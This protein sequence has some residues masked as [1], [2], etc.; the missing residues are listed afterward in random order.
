MAAVGTLTIEMAANVARLQRDM[1]RAY[2]TVDGAMG[3]INRSVQAATRIFGGFAAALSVQKIIQQADA[4]SLLNS[5]LK[6][7]TSSQ[8]ELTKVQNALFAISSKTY[9]STEATV[10]LYAA[11]ARSTKNLNVTQQELLT[12]VETFN[13]SI[14]ISGGSVQSAQ[15]AITQ[16]NQAMA[17]GVLRGE[18]FN[19]ISEQA[20]MIMELLSES[21]GV[22]RG[23]LR[24]MAKEG[25][26]TAELVLPALIDG[27]KG[28]DEQFERMPKTVGQATN[29]LAQSFALL[30]AD[31]DKSTGASA[32]L[33]EAI[34]G[35]ASSIKGLSAFVDENK[36]ALMAWAGILLA[37]AIIAGIGTLITSLIALKG[38]I[39]GVGAA[40]AANP[41]GLALLAITAAAIPA[42]DALNKYLSARQ[43]AKEAEDA[44]NESAAETARLLRQQEE[45]LKRNETA[46]TSRARAILE[47]KKAEEEQKKIAEELQKTYDT[48]IKR[49]Q[50]DLIKSTAAL[51]AEQLGLNKAQEEF[52]ALVAGPAWKKYTNEQRLLITSLYRQRIEVEQIAEAEKQRVKEKED[53]QKRLERMLE[54]EN[55]ARRQF[56]AEDKK[57]EEER[58]RAQEK[59]YKEQQKNIEKINDALTDAL[60]QAFESGKGFGQA[61]KDTLVNM[62]KTMVLR[63]ILAPIV[64]GA[65]ASFGLPAS[66]SDMVGTAGSTMNILTG[67]KS[68]WDMVS[69][70]F[71]ALGNSVAFA[72]DSLGAWLVNNTTGMLNQAGASLMQSA[73]ALGTAASYFGGVAAGYAIGSII[74]GGFSAIGKNPNTAVVAGTAIGTIFGGPLGGAIGGAIGGLVNR[75]FGMGP[76]K[77]TDTGIRGSFSTEGAALGGYSNWSQKGGWFR[78]S[79]SGTNYAPVDLQLDQFLDNAI[80][81]VASATRSYARLLNLNADAINGVTRSI[82][83][84]LAGLTPE[85]QQEAILKELQAF[86]DQLAAVYVSNLVKPGES[87]IQVLE[88]LATSLLAVNQV[89]DTLSV[90][91]LDY[92]LKGSE[93]AAR[94]VNAFGSVEDFASLT[95]TYYQNY[96]TEAE[97]SANATRQLTQVM[98]AL[99]FAVP[100]SRAE[101][102]QL[103]EAQ[104]LYTEAG[105]QNYAA[106][107]RLSVIFDEITPKI[108]TLAGKLGNLIGNM[109]DGI[110]NDL[111]EQ[112][113]LSQQ[114]AQAAKQAAQDFAEAGKLL[115][116]AS[117][118]TLVAAQS[119]GIRQQYQSALAAARGGDIEAMRALP[120]LGSQL[121]A[122]ERS[123]ATSSVGFALVSARISAEMQSVAKMAEEFGAFSDYQAMLYDVNTAMLEVLQSQ[124]RSGNLTVEGLQ[125][126][127]E[128]LQAMSLLIQEGNNYQGETVTLTDLVSKA[129][130][131][132]EDLSSMILNQLKV[133]DASAQFLS[134]TIDAGNLHIADRLLLVVAA[135]NQQTEA[136]QAEI[137]R[138]QDLTNAQRVLESI[139]VKQQQTITEVNAGIAD[140]WALANKTGVFLNKTAGP[141]DFTQSAMFKVNEQ[142]LFEALY[143]QITYPSSASQATAFKSS[144]YAPGGAYERTYGRR[145]ELAEVAAELERQRQVIRDL[146]GVPAFAAGGMHSGG[147]RIVGERGPE[148]ELTGPARYMSNASLSSMMSGETAQEIRDLREENKVQMRAI[149]SLQSRMTRLFERWDTDGL[150]EERAVA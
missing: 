91:L 132:N 50:E 126:N 109:V 57:A 79:R 135:I 2:R 15:A 69:G 71:A 47:A 19:S 80:N 36:Y 99:G 17:S 86:G 53:N 127:F 149:V 144:F 12:V 39:I 66:A 6:L 40:L 88:K 24:E 7:V 84:S 125:R 145:G 100:N 58:L 43:K 72:A 26:L 129:T 4:M 8:A 70:G 46:V 31:I 141:L 118:S 30:I 137:K 63:P 140:I 56:M 90:S 65:T 112:I 59:L 122:F 25:L 81:T 139:A 117:L 114:A 123:N 51:Q 134:R 11:L 37:P 133:P 34:S 75:A 111:D 130:K 82:N 131:G 94:L 33:A 121:Q 55:E 147:M 62:F 32:K 115:R 78:S 68:A 138:Q 1:D 107:I 97:R 85:Q 67:V 106:L 150:P 95:T 9:T 20:P 105:R 143:N 14:I 73:G 110:L 28:V 83:L 54:D 142:G 101:L 74:S 49:L 42:I 77:T 102:R 18:E 13:K 124:L 29:Q 35:L 61:F 48:L 104:D 96:Y 3:K 64:A 136:Q 27:A 76:M 52:L 21:L 98:N 89:F 5:R 108:D 10:N 87:A 116:E 119:A 146:G 103:I 22:T 41:I 113:A 38:A 128:A 120:G 23:A 148:L 92:S 93:A 44:S 60:M 16:F 45:A